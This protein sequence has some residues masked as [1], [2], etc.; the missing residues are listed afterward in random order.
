MGY[1][2]S[3]FHIGPSLSA[4]YPRSHCEKR[5]RSTQCAK[6]S[7]NCGLRASVKLRTS[8]PGNRLCHG[9]VHDRP[10]QVFRTMRRASRRC[11]RGDGEEAF[12]NRFPTQLGSSSTLS[13]D[14]GVC[15]RVHERFN[16]DACCSTG[17]G[18]LCVA[19]SE[20]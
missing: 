9:C 4:I 12:W 1:A 11:I 3:L 2:W 7:S 18:T 5:T 20:L 10:V 8:P 13:S 15:S 6:K 17:R 14:A 16:M 19:M